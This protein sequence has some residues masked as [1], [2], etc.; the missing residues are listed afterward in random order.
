MATRTRRSMAVAAVV[1]LAVA[2]CGGDDSAKSE[3][4]ELRATLDRTSMELD[5]VKS[6][7]EEA[8]ALVAALEAELDDVQAE[9]DTAQAAAE[10]AAGRTEGLEQAVAAAEAARDA[11]AAE[12]AD[13]RL[14]F[15]PEIQA[16]LADLTN[17][18]A[19]QACI[20]ADEAG[21]SG[22]PAPA[23]D[24][25]I[26]RI[27]LTRPV[28]IAQAD[29]T[30]RIDR[31]VVEQRR[32]ECYAAGQARVAEEWLISPKGDGIWT[33]G[34]EMAAGRWRSNG[35]GDSCYWQISPDGRPDSIINNHFGNAGG[36]VTLQNGQEFESDRCGQWEKVG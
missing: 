11:A 14:R 22:A 20:D 30:A 31:T 2:G 25:A 28:G 3:A 23:I 10:E 32:D 8:A 35:S 26:R 4:E 17:A 36:T 12:A 1:V 33:V 9:L 29:A 24:V 19:E 27:V 16:L 13:L 21:Y 6:D 18:A 15:D 7:H 5:Q 34:V